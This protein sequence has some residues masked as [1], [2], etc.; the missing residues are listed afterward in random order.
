MEHCGSETKGVPECRLRFRRK[1]RYT[2]RRRRI[3]AG[4]T[5]FR[6][7][8]L[9]VATVQGAN[10]RTIARLIP[11]DIPVTST[12]ESSAIVFDHYSLFSALRIVGGAGIRGERIQST[13]VLWMKTARENRPLW[14]PVTCHHYRHCDIFSR[15]IR[16]CSDVFSFMPCTRFRSS[17]WMERTMLGG[18][19]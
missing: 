19:R 16:G 2:L 17:I 15:T 14:H 9:S 8:I 11:A 1:G 7:V 18:H 10:A 5:L 4:S 13:V 6:S 12:S 3:D